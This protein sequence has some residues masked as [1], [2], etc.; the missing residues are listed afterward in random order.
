MPRKLQEHT[1]RTNFPSRQPM[2]LLHLRLRAL[3]PP[4]LRDRLEEMLHVPVIHRLHHVGVG[5]KLIRA[6]DIAGFIRG[7]HNDHRDPFQI[8]V[9]LDPFQHLEPRLARHL[10]VHDHQPRHR[11]LP[12]VPILA[13]ALQIVNRFH[14]IRH[15]LEWIGY[16]SLLERAFD[17]KNIVEV[18]L[19]QQDG[20]VIV[21]FHTP[22]TNSPDNVRRSGPTVQHPHPASQ[23]VNTPETF[24]L[25]RTSRC[26]VRAAW[27]RRN[28]L[29][30]VTDI[31]RT[32]KP[33]A[34][35]ASQPEPPFQPLPKSIRRLTSSAPPESCRDSSLSAKG[36]PDSERA[37]PGCPAVSESTLQELNQHPTYLP[38]NG[39]RA[40]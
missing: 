12:P 20:E 25:A 11:I 27:Q 7:R 14:P 39:R 6:I 40:A 26:N 30:E 19:N 36:W 15:D 29:A 5:P 34:A 31:Q 17:E 10:D 9:A 3:E 16:S 18:V 2:L 4:I 32:S 38:E 37:Y 13:L 23:S 21:V 24:P 8:S 35:H 1:E 33:F 22:S 28:V